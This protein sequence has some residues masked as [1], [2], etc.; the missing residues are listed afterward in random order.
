MG[1]GQPD[2]AGAEDAQDVAVAEQR[3]VAFGL[4]RPGDHAVGASAEARHDLGPSDPVEPVAEWLRA[5]GLV[6]AQGAIAV[7]GHLPFLDH[8][9]SLL[10]TGD[11]DTHVVRF[12]NA[13]LVKLVPKEELPGYCV[14]WLLPPALA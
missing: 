1:G 8:L 9:A 4:E 6:A 14:A 2:P 12:H 5:Q 13:A 10:V 7:V 11:A 3:D